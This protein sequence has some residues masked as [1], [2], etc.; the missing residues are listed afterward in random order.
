MKLA[1]TT[2]FGLD[3]RSHSML[4]NTCKD[5]GFMD[6]YMSGYGLIYLSEK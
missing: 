6:M 3:M 1:H 4:K 2:N 5:M